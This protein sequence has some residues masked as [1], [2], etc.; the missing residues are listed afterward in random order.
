MSAKPKSMS[1]AKAMAAVGR[2]KCVSRLAWFRKNKR[3]E[4]KV[5]PMGSSIR[6]WS[7]TRFAWLCCWNDIDDILDESKLANDWVICKRPST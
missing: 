4:S 3:F 7:G 2:G 5:V 6:V 1:F